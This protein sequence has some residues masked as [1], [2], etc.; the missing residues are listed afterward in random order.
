M[1]GEP[2]ENNSQVRRAPDLRTIRLFGIP[3]SEIN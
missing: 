1:M 3:E 2:K